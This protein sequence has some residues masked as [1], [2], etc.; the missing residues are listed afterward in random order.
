MFNAVDA[1]QCL[2]NASA[3]AIFATM[4]NNEQKVGV[5]RYGERIGL[6]Q[7][8]RPGIYRVGSI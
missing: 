1:E 7:D 6:G 4:A 2:L 5:L 3:M 8:Q